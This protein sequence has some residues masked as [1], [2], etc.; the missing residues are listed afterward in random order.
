MS[1]DLLERPLVLT[2]R[3]AR[4]AGMLHE[5]KSRKLV[6]MCHGFMGNKIENK[7]LFVDAARVFAESGFCVLRFD[8]YGSGDSQGDFADSLITTNIANLS[9]VLNWARNE[10]YE[11]IAVLGLSMGAAT[12]ILTCADTQVDALVAWSAVPDM[13][14]LFTSYLENFHEIVKKNDWF[15]YEGWQIKK[16]FWEDA[17]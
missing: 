3:G 2:S 7:R 16:E 5:S 1:G 14:K 10:G 6:V 4:L 13:K 15:E 17:A 8:F 12:A 9:D 11:R